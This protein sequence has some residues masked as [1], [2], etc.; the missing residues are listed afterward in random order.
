MVPGS[1]FVSRDDFF[2]GVCQSQEIYYLHHY[3]KSYYFSLRITEIILSHKK[4]RTFFFTVG[5]KSPLDFF[6]VISCEASFNVSKMTKRIR[7]KNKDKPY[8]RNKFFWK[9][10]INLKFVIDSDAIPSQYNASSQQF[11]RTYR[12]FSCWRLRRENANKLTCRFGFHGLFSWVRRNWVD[13]L[14]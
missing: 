10:L 1:F 12:V 5:N 4:S 13:G 6:F 9:S 3:S 7:R 11:C 2:R 14:V 8:A